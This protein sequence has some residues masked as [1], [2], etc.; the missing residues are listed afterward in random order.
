MYRTILIYLPLFFLA[1][2]NCQE[3]FLIWNNPITSG[4]N[5]YGMKD[6]FIFQE[7]DYYYLVGTEYLNP[8][9]PQKSL[10]IYK[11]KDLINWSKGELLIPNIENGAWFRDEW[12]SPE[13]HVYKDKYYLTFNAR[14]NDLRP[15]KKTGFVIAV[16]NQIEG[17]YIVI[18]TK[19][20]LI[21]SNNGGLLFF[22]DKIYLYYDMDGR[23]Y[24]AEID[25]PSATLVSKPYEILGPASLGINYKFVDAP[26]IAKIGNTYHLLFTQF[27]G[28]YEVKVFHMTAEDPTET[29][30]W[31]ANNPLYTFLESEAED[32]V[33]MEYPDKHG[34]AP[35][36]QVIFHHQLFLDE[37]GNIFMVY[38]SSEKYSEPYLCI[39]PVE[40]RMNQ[41]LLIEPKNSLQKIKR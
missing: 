29:W 14:N 28:G 6:Y 30:K 11:S 39:E 2:V 41:I 18:N 1:R 21:F 32:I 7:H 26:Q 37:I 4:I 34:F 27:Y 16:S 35:P 31:T 10:S 33:K 20:P 13:I 17:P 8:Y 5:P 40:L 22:K 19:K 38:H 24:L 15:Y 12:R 9:N 3:D 23:V 36:T 25:L